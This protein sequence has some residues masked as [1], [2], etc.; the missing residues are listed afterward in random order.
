MFLRALLLALC[1]GMALSALTAVLAHAQDVPAALT[2]QGSATLSDARKGA[3]AAPAAAQARPAVQPDAGV[4][5][6][7]QAWRMA[8]DYDPS[9]KAAISERLAADTLR[10]QGR[11]GLLPQIQ[12]GYVRSRINGD[13]EQPDFLGRRTSS[14]VSYDSSNAYVQLQQPLLDYGRYAGYKRGAAM[15]REGAETFTVRQQQ[16]GARVATAYL[17]VL[18][19]HERVALQ[20]AR[21][22]TLQDR[23]KT[24]QARFARDAGTATDVKETAARLAVA[25]ADEIAARDELLVAQRELQAMIGFAPDAIAGLGEAFT[26]LPLEPANLREWLRRA[27]ENNPSVQAARASVDVSQAGV[28]QARSEYWPSVNLVAS[29]SNADSENLSTLS[30]RS[31]TYVVGLHV[32]IPIFTGGYTSAN[33]SQARNE[34]R[35]RQSELDAAREKALA[36]AT[37]QYSN[38]TNGAERIRA[39][40][41]AV[42]SGKLSVMAARKAFSYGVGSN[43]EVLDEQDLL[44]R[45]Q[46][47]LAQARLEYLLAWLQLAHV[48]GELDSADFDA[49]SNAYLTRTIA[50]DPARQAAV[51]PHARPWPRPSASIQA[52]GVQ[53][54]DMQ[55]VSAQDTFVVA[56]SLSLSA[57]L[58]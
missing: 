30:Q 43:L 20:Q 29:Y 19:A 7:S 1:V 22:A 51:A 18:L 4:L 46:A 16:M 33:V 36:D 38:V 50:L 58:N 26:L 54:S 13:I 17:E 56:D 41:S 28:E 12:A 49:I 45:A 23:H 37:R 53:A 44:F 15:A 9:Y 5:D 3:G 6:L 57:T 8:L 21:V 25:R 14:D 39:L 34:Y 55:V 24:Q 27:S 32:A 47:A 10:R 52:A 42:A 40:E 11:A 2:L 48:A 35:Q 31:N